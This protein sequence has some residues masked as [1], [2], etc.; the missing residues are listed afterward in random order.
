MR[1]K[2]NTYNGFKILVDTFIKSDVVMAEIGSYAGDSSAIF[3]SKC[4][5]IY[6]IDPWS[7]DI[8]K[9]E[10]GVQVGDISEAES[11]FDENTK[12]FNNLVKIKKT[13]DDAAKDIEDNSLDFLYI[14]GLHTF[15]QVTKDIANYYPKVK[16]TGIIAGHDFNPVCWKGVQQAIQFSLGEPH[17]VFPDTSWAFKK[18][19]FDELVNFV[20][21]YRGGLPFLHTWKLAENGDK[22][23]YQEIKLF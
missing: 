4:K 3:A 13:S 16:K 20:V 1:D 21:E 22:K 6:C 9:T 7:Q 14:D 15:E 2:A 12:K 8:L 23:D 5:K 19:L 17:F 11:K 18:S 10:Y